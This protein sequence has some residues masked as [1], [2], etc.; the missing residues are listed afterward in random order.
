MSPHEASRSPYACHVPSTVTSLLNSVG[1]DPGG[2]APWGTPLPELRPGVYVVALTSTTD[3]VGSTHARAPFSGY[4]LD[5]L[6]TACPG[7]S[8]DGVSGP[9]RDQLAARMGQYWLPDE[10]VLYIGLTGRPLRNRVRQYYKTPLGAAKPHAGGWWLKTLAVLDAL[11]VH[12]AVTDDYK[13]AEEEM[14]RAFAANVSAVSRDRLPAGEPAMPFAN[15]RDGRWRR[16]AHGIRGATGAAAK[17]ADPKPDAPRSAAAPARVVGTTSRRS[18]KV[19]A[20]DIEAGQVRIPGETKSLLPSERQ[21]ITVRLHGQH[22]TC[23][24]DPRH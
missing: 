9:T 22:L 15:L 5:A 6:I 19:T 13:D 1:L 20:K 23:R 4:A 18:Q 14:L 17:R 10:C 21:D 2:C 7:L 3:R 8:L 24:W 16:R 11:V 12:Y